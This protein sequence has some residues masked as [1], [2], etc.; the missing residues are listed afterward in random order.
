MKKNRRSPVAAVLCAIVLLAGCAGNNDG[1][2]QT[3]AQTETAAETDLTVGEI[4][5]KR[6]D[7]YKLKASTEAGNSGDVTIQPG[8]TYTVITVRDFG[9]IK[10]KLFP[11]LAPYSVYNFTEI[12]KRGDY[13]GRS[14]HR[15]LENF[16]IQGGSPDGGGGGECFDGG[17][18]KNEVNTSLRHYYGALCYAASGIGDISDGFYI[19]NS[20]VNDTDDLGKMYDNLAFNSSFTATVNQYYIEALEPDTENYDLLMKYYTGSLIYN[21]AIVEGVSAMKNTITDAVT[22]TYAEKGGR[23]SLDGSYTVFGQTVEGFD[24]IDKITAVEK[25]VGVD[26]KESKPVDDIIIDKVEIFTA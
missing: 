20:K 11:D 9:E 10:V 7:R 3:G 6:P 26:G 2:Q 5:G 4:D 16:M 14:F 8:D 17:T 24:V 15:I 25:T 22:K 1:G 19:V 13:N 18:F 12:A 21:S 23:S